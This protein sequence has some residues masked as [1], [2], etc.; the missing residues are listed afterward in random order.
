MKRWTRGQSNKTVRALDG[1]IKCEQRADLT[2]LRSLKRRNPSRRLGGSAVLILALVGASLTAVACGQVITEFPVPTASSTPEGI[3]PGP[4]DARGTLFTFRRTYPFDSIPFDA[5]HKAS[6][7]RPKDWIQKSEAGAAPASS[8]WH[9]IGPTPSNYLP[10]TV[11][12]V[13]GRIEAIAVS[14][15]DPRLT[16]I[17]GSPGGIWRSTDGGS[18]FTPVADDQVDIAV[19]G[20]AFSQC[21]PTQAG[22]LTSDGSL[23][24]S[25]FYVSTNGSDPIDP[26][27]IY[28]GRDIGVFRSPSRGD[29]WFTFHY[30]LPAAVVTGSGAQSSGLIRLSTYGRGMYK[31]GAPQRLGIERVSP[32]TASPRAIAPR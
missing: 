10:A 13:S 11:G 28:V 20:I 14:S 29:V 2:R 1:T 17:G 3:V 6:D 18:A 32:R 23:T 4:V 19:G 7:S 8:V 27:T 30:G 21:D 25:G 9:S 24:G 22:L 12:E 31:L 15:L 16:L 26:S 5:R